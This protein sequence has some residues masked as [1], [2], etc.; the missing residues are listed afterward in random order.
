MFS[1]LWFSRARAVPRIVCCCL[2]SLEAQAQAMYVAGVYG[3]SFDQA[4]AQA[5][6]VVG[7]PV[8]LPLPPGPPVR[9]DRDARAE[10][11]LVSY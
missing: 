4:Q 9:L 8:P 3:T 5:S 6:Y 10:C 11:T 1:L 2:R 7:S